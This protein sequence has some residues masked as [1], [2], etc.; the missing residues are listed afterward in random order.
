MV[1]TVT[2]VAL[3]LGFALHANAG[4]VIHVP[5]RDCTA[6]NKA[7]SSVE[8]GDDTTIILARHGNYVSRD[9]GEGCGISVRSGR[10]VID[11][12][13]AELQPLC[14][15]GVIDV[16]A[17]AQLT[18]RNALVSEPSCGR[19]PPFVEDVR[20]DGRID[21]ESVTFKKT[22]SRLVNSAGASMT[23][24]N[25]TL[26]SGGIDNGGALWILNSTLL[27]ADVVNTGN[28]TIDIGNSIAASANR[29]ACAVAGAG[30]QSH[31]GNVVASSCA[32][33]AAADVRPADPGTG[34]GPLQ[35]NGGI[36]IPTFALASA[37]PAR[38]AG[39]TNQCEPTDARGVARQVDACD[40]GAYAFDATKYLGSGGMDGTWYEP[41]AGGHY[42]TI[43][44]VHDNGDVLV[45]WNAFDRNGNQAWI[46]GV[47]RVADRHIHVD[48]AQNIGGRL[49]TG[50]APSESSTRAWGTVDIDLSSC[51]EGT[52]RYQSTVPDFGS[53][54]FKLDRLAYISDFG[55]VD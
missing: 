36:G 48:M 53:G 6:L 26:S 43:Q 37:S 25:V 16:A 24:R 46:Y 35:N 52:M 21:F 20:N 32:W 23:L 8:E 4:P 9:V 38:N 49:Q 44:R 18:L 14:V 13:G 39:I 29:S 2:I 54:Q 42:V 11:A 47:G 55:C 41:A 17:G 30:V 19:T 31:G 33:T 15:S 50:G 7:V 1:R 10:V 34:L 3:F 22:V 27:S 12:A 5:D 28:A 40:A 51:L 45:I